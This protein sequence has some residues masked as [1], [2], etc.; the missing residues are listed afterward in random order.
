VTD[1]DFARLIERGHELRG[2]EYKPPGKRGAGDLMA[3][4]TRAA[5][6]MANHRDGGIV[7][8]GVDESGGSPRPVGLTPEELETWGY[9]DIAAIL[10]ACSDPTLSFEH[11]IRTYNGMPYVVLRV[12]EFAEV[13]ILAKKDML[14][15]RNKQI[16]RKGG[17]YVRSLGKPETSEIPSQDEMRDLLDLAIQKGIRKFVEQA[18]GAG[19]IVYRP[20]P[21]RPASD[22][23]FLRQLGEFLR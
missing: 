14:G 6:G 21:A 22:A 12:H 7:I 18:V 10:A 4:V 9:D 1:D 13:P 3:W 2:I 20:S 23:E 15:E 5:L 16:I 19:L 8:I 17:C 11:E